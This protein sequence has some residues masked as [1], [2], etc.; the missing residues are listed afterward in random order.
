MLQDLFVH[1]MQVLVNMVT[2]MCT[3]GSRSFQSRIILCKAALKL[4]AFVRFFDEFGFGFDRAEF[5]A[6]LCKGHQ[7]CNAG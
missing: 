7:Y 6:S 4:S 3:F 1:S 5:F 2:S